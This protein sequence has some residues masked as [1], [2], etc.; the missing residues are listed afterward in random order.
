MPTMKYA[1]CRAPLSRADCSR[2]RARGEEH[3][4][5]LGEVREKLGQLVVELVVRG[6]DRDQ[7]GGGGL[8]LV[9]LGHV[10]DEALAGLGGADQGDAQRRLVEGGRAELDEV[11]DGLD[12]LLG[13]RLVGEGAGGAGLAEE[14]VLGGG[15]KYERHGRNLL[16]KW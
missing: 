6:E 14:E 13:H 11:V 3:V 15:V 4:P 12:L 5:G 1:A 16:D 10:L 7:R 9:A 8:G 2:T